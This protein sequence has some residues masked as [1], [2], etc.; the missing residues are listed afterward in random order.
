MFCSNCG[1]EV[2]DQA[3]MCVS[4]GCPPRSARKFCWNCA[5]ATDPM[6]EFCV[7]CG[8]RLGGAPAPAGSELKSKMAAGLLGIFLGSLGIHRFYLGFNG[9]GIAQLVLGLLGILTCGMTT[10]AAHI[11]G[12]IEGI[13]IL[14]GSINRDAQGRPLK[15]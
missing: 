11:W 8:V 14:T 5:A 3:V 7:K 6:A 2:A 13:L 1:K 10:V 12:L 4:C 9:I 15:E